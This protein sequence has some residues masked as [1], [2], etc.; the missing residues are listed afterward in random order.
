MRKIHKKL[1]IENKFKLDSEKAI[2]VMNASNI[3][4]NSNPYIEAKTKAKENEYKI[5]CLNNALKKYKSLYVGP[6][7]DFTNDGKYI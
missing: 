5:L 4:K 7:I 1:E 2:E 3:P 6:S